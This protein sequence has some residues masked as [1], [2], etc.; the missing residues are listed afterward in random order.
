MAHTPVK[1]YHQHK[2]EE[3]KRYLPICG[4]LFF[5]ALQFGIIVYAVMAQ[6]KKQAEK[7][8]DTKKDENSKKNEQSDTKADGKKNASKDT[9]GENKDGNVLANNGTQ[10]SKNT[11]DNNNPDENNGAANTTV[12]KAKK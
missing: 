4:G 8:A 1:R 11:P 10:S 3:W 9:K 2:S 12:D 5:F 7:V 6:K